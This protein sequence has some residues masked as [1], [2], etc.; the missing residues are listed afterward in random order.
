MR[1]RNR[2]HTVE[3]LLSL[4]I[5]DGDCL[6]WQGASHTQQGYGVVVLMGKQTTAHRAMYQL[7]TGQPV[8]LDMEVDHMCNNRACINPAHLQLVS[9]AENM[10]LGL[11]RR[12]HCRAGHEWTEESTYLAVVQRKQGGTRMQRYCRECRKLYQRQLRERTT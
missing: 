12:T 8:A 4:T 3:S 1:T 5:P 2:P 10:R 9:H 11:K 6:I 7:H